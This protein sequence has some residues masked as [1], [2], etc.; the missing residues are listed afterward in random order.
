MGELFS[1]TVYERRQPSKENIL[2]FW[3][4]S[5]IINICSGLEDKN[6]LAWIENDIKNSKVYDGLSGAFKLI[7]LSWSVFTSSCRDVIL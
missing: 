1:L 3:L 6:F 2:P 7:I 4:S 5:C